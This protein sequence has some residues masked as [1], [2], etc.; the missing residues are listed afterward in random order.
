MATIRNVDK[1]TVNV[2]YYTAVK[3]SSGNETET[4]NTLYTNIIVDIQPWTGDVSQVPSGAI[5]NPTHMI[6]QEVNH[7]DINQYYVFV[8]GTEKYEVVFVYDYAGE[9]YYLARRL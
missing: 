6:F 1:K 2:V 5:S 9:N 4:T 7:T 8:Y 3:D